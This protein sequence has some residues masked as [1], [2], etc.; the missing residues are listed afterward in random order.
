MLRV[1]GRR[2]EGNKGRREEGNKGIK[3][4]LLE[5]Q[6]VLTT[7]TVAISKITL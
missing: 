5:T 4:R 2:E 6:N 1:R 7:L 3:S